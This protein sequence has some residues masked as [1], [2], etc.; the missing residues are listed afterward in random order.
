MGILAGASTHDVLAAVAG[1]TVLHALGERIV[2]ALSGV[3]WRAD[4]LRPAD[5]VWCVGVSV[6]VLAG[7]SLGWWAGGW[8]FAGSA[9]PAVTI[10]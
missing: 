10:T 2:S 4:T 5:L 7:A 9:R 1:A 8:G 3:A 6:G